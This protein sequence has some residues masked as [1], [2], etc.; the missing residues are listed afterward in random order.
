[1]REAL[2]SAGLR[3]GQIAAVGIG[4]AGAAARHSA[5]WLREVTS[6]VTPQ[7]Q[8]VPSAD[9]EI[10]L[11]GALGERRGVLV[12]AGTGSLAYGVNDAGEA[13]LVGGWG[14]LLDDKGSG[15]WI[16]QQGLQ[17]V[18]QAEDGRGPETSL[19]RILLGAL[20]L[21]KPLDVIAWLYRS[22]T[23]RTR[24]VAQL[25]PLVL[26][27]AAGGDSVA[28]QIVTQAV[29][30]LARAAQTVIRRLKLDH[31]GFAFTG[32]LLTTPNPLSEGLC[33]ALGLD[34]LPSPRYPPVIGAALLAWIALGKHNS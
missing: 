14:Y 26:D 1:M 15:Y 20:S 22:E 5:D 21:E 28:Q 27:Q 11:V 33:R 31:P 3:P 17:A 25:A 8:I 34:R 6:G 32:G 9:Y 23:P 7:A 10:A 12:L 13:A 24:D 30:E 2:H 18:I 4:I 16:G 19:T 29:T